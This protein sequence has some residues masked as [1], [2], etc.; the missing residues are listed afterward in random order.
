[1]HGGCLFVKSWKNSSDRPM[2]RSVTR[3][4]VFMVASKT[5][6]MDVGVDIEPILLTVLDD[7]FVRARYLHESF[8]WK[9][10]RS[11]CSQQ[12]AQAQS[13]LLKLSVS[14]VNVY[15][16]IKSQTFAALSPIHFQLH[17]RQVRSN[18][19]MSQ[20]DSPPAT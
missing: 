3:S 10:A 4:L 13:G 8:L 6:I 16:I 15:I 9:L 1:M 11:C 17:K 12:R 7:Q 5:R 18:N 20:D 19:Q 2:S 14:P